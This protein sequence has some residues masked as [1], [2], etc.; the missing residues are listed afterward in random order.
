MKPK[1]TKRI[2]DIPD[3]V[4]ELS[5]ESEEMDDS[6]DTHAISST[7]IVIEDDPGTSL[8]M[9]QELLEALQKGSSEEEH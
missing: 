9:A 7:A 6:D 8:S 5:S 3:E 4:I 1:Q 2:V